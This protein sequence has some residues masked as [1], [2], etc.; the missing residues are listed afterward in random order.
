[1]T[2]HELYYLAGFNDKHDLQF[3]INICSIIMNNYYDEYSIFKRKHLLRILNV[4]TGCGYT[5]SLSF[6]YYFN[7]LLYIRCNLKEHIPH[8]FITT[9]KEVLDVINKVIEYVKQN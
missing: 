5:R 4:W 1:M 3:K 7:V 8:N 2:M 6:D 9:D